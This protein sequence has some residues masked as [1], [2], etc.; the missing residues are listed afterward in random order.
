[1]DTDF[2]LYRPEFN[3]CELTAIISSVPRG[4]FG[5]LWDWA[6]PAKRAGI[7]SA[8]YAWGKKY[9]VIAGYVTYR[10]V[11]F[12]WRWIRSLEICRVF[13]SW[14][15]SKTGKNI[16]VGFRE[17]FMS[18]F[19]LKPIK[20]KEGHSHPDAAAYRTGA[21]RSI[22][23]FIV[24]QGMEPYSVSTSKRDLSGTR[25]VYEPKD[26]DLIY[27]NDTIK[28][29]HVLKM[30]DTDYYVDMDAWL[31]HGRPILLYTFAP[32]KAGG[33]ITDGNFTI[34]DNM[35]DC[36]YNGGGHWR[37]ELWDYS[38]DHITVRG[39]FYTLMVKIDQF[40]VAGDDQRKIVL[41][42]PTTWSWNAVT[43]S[44][45]KHKPL[46]RRQLSHG[47]TNVI[48]YLGGDNKNDAYVS[49]SAACMS[50]AI[51][52][53]QDIISSL[54]IRYIHASKPSIGDIERILK[55]EVLKLPHRSATLAAPLLFEAFEKGFS[56]SK[57]DCKVVTTTN[58]PQP[59]HYQFIKPIV[60]EDASASGQVLGPAIITN[61]GF[62]PVRGYNADQATIQ[63]R[64]ERPKKDKDG[65]PKEMPSYLNM[66]INEFVTAFPADNLSPVSIDQVQAAMTRPQQRTRFEK[67][68]HFMA[69]K[70]GKIG[71]FMKLEAQTGFKVPRNISQ[72]STDHTLRFSCYTHA[73]KDYFKDYDFW[74]PGR[75]PQEITDIL[76]KFA[77]DAEI[78]HET[79][80]ESFDGN[81]TA[82]LCR[83]VLAIFLRIF[84][85]KYHKDI[86]DLFEQEIKALGRTKYGVEYGIDGTRISGSPITTIGN[87]LIAWLVIYT[88]ARKAGIIKEKAIKDVPG[89]G[90]GDD[91]LS[92]KI[93]KADYETIAREF[94]L[95]VTCVSHHRL[96]D[97][98][99][100]G[101]LGRVFV[102]PWT[103]RTSMQD[104]IRSLGRMHLSVVKNVPVE[105]VKRNKAKGFEHSDTLTPILSAVVH[106]YLKET[107]EY[108]HAWQQK[109]H[110]LRVDLP[111]F[112]Q[113]VAAQGDDNEELKEELRK[114]KPKPN[115]LLQYKLWEAKLAKIKDIGTWEQDGA[116]VELMVQIAATRLNRTPDE[117]RRLHDE[118]IATVGLA[119]TWTPFEYELP[120]TKIPIMASDR[121]ISPTP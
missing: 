52:L 99:S 26:L 51:D 29:S 89:I 68:K 77:T 84:D 116:D 21:D 114:N 67:A 9:W 58:V 115:Q 14:L 71:A 32:T 65:K 81:I 119:T 98:R 35:V 104:P 38:E 46:A 74:L 88:A 23:D 53:P 27:R 93:S 76:M 42:T 95:P 70:L 62:L 117:V 75:T 12:L 7:Y 55:T 54:A 22:D 41:L 48:K 36:R 108:E 4:Y 28:N 40:L 30:I 85:E 18:S 96:A 113:W 60:W 102:D 16:N 10:S 73:L 106:K 19:E 87:T 111:Y 120:N 8:Q 64:V 15:H 103:T 37:H 61:N 33:P 101:L 6:G 83:V 97:D 31:W 11:R 44:L 57:T 80:F 66:Y 90:F 94:G 45:C 34:K 118:I 78:I 25:Y 17:T 47:D 91:G 109:Q 50:S 5:P 82:K 92:K 100:I 3:S 63:W 110:M 69:E 112:A 86:K 13:R 59:F 2:L 43:D 39:T 72:C 107:E 56:I 1:M 121:Y 20:A 24:M 105:I 79:D 49:L